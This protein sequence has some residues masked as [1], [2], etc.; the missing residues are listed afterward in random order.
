MSLTLTLSGLSFMIEFILNIL[1]LNIELNYYLHQFPGSASRVRYRT[2]QSTVTPVILML[3]IPWISLA[4]SK[5]IVV[6]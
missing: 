3:W 4:S 6:A 2:A 1:I 5:P